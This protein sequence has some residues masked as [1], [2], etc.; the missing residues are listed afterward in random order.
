MMI[1]PGF[2]QENLKANEK[3]DFGLWV[4]YSGLLSCKCSSCNTWAAGKP[5]NYCGH[6]GALMV[7]KADAMLRYELELEKLQEGGQQND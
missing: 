5:D 6:C 4:F 7:N 1:I 2:D 3:R